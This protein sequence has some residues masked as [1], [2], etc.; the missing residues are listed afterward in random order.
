MGRDTINLDKEHEN[1]QVLDL[2]SL[3]TWKYTFFFLFEVPVG[4]P[5]GDI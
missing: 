3:N 4:Y 5:D 2:L 1:M